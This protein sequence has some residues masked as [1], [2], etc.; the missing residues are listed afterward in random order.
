MPA[1]ARLPLPALSK[2]V[3]GPARPEPLTSEPSANEPSTGEPLTSEPPLQPAAVPRPLGGPR[4]GLV[5]AFDAPPAAGTAPLTSEP[6]L[7]DAT[8]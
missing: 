6:P 3:P 7:A 4:T 1:A 8:P 5:A 2:Q